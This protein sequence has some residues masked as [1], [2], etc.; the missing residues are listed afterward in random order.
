MILENIVT[1]DSKLVKSE[2]CYYTTVE[3][4]PI[5]EPVDTGTCNIKA[6]CNP[7]KIISCQVFRPLAKDQ[8][9]AV[10]LVKI[11]SCQVFRWKD[12]C[13]HIRWFSVDHRPIHN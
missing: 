8:P 2:F 11:I 13:Y 5:L 6:V 1:Y 3:I 4:W 9:L 10:Q 7:V 12:S